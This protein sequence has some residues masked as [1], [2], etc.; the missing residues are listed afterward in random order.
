MGTLKNDKYSL[1]FIGSYFFGKN[2]SFSL[3]VKS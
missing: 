1:K 2:T 3:I